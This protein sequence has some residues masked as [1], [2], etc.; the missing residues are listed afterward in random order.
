VRLRA[1]LL[2]LPLLFVACGSGDD[3]DVVLDDFA[4]T[5]PLPSDS[6]TTAAPPVTSD[7]M[8]LTSTAF[9]DGGT[10]PVE[11]TCD[12]S[13][14]EPELTWTGEPPETQVI[15]ITVIDSNNDVE[16][17]IRIGDKDISPWFGPCPPSDGAHS[18]VFTVHA[19]GTVDVEQT[20]AGIEAVTIA[21]A[22][23]TGLY[24]APPDSG[25]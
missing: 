7:G 23:I 1:V 13:D 20:R 2:V 9:T 15:A 18:Y 19:L 21:S 11:F 6:T 17:W 8:M 25:R 16:H 22:T 4:D 14:A 24:E 12:G 3:D 5:I 10:I